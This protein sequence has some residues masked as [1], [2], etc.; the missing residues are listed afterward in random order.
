VL[1]TPVYKTSPSVAKAHCVNTA[2]NG[3]AGGGRARPA[4]APPRA[5]SAGDAPMPPS[6][7]IPRAQASPRAPKSGKS[8]RA[9]AAPAAPAAAAV[10]ASPRGA[11]VAPPSAKRLRR[12]PSFAPRKATTP[13][14]PSASHSASDDGSGPAGGAA[15]GA[16]AAPH[17]APHPP[18]REPLDAAPAGAADTPRDDAA[19][20]RRLHAE[21][22]CTPARTSR[23]RA[24]AACRVEAAPRDRAHDHDPG[25]LPSC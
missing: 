13:A 21:L 10:A 17:T 3:A 4:G 8:P 23:A 22:N 25:L 11:G 19:L 7:A 16:S 6:P 18:P 20:A 9:P 15:G 1:F 5:S 2:G 14:T 12:D 24:A